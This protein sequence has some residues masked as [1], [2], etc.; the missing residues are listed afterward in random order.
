MGQ[1][2]DWPRDSKS[3]DDLFPVRRHFLTQ[4]EEDLYT[5]NV[6]LKE[7][8]ESLRLVIFEMAKQTTG[9]ILIDTDIHTM[10]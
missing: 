8:N 10:D 7:E 6:R 2:P 3:A 9:K 4:G 5:E 1:N